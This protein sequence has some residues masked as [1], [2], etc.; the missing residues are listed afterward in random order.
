MVSRGNRNRRIGAEERRPGA[1]AS[2]MRMLWNNSAVRSLSIGENRDPKKENRL[3]PGDGFPRSQAAAAHAPGYGAGM[4]SD[5]ADSFQRFLAGVR[6]KTARRLRRCFEENHKSEQASRGR[7]A[8]VEP[9]VKRL[10]RCPEQPG[11]FF[12][13]QAMGAHEGAQALCHIAAVV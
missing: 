4:Q 9:V 5:R 8:L 3:P 11:K 13:A 10:R 6:L 2:G 7:R 1:A 12:Q